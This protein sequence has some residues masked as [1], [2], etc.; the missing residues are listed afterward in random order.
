MHHYLP[1]MVSACDY[2]LPRRPGGRAAT[3][4][5]PGCAPPPRHGVAQPKALVGARRARAT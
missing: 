4:A 3:A 1:S 2:R 5:Q